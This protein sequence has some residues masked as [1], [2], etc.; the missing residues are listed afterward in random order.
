[1]KRVLTLIILLSVFAYLFSSPS[2]YQNPRR[3]YEPNQ[4]IV[5][6]GSGDSYE[7]AMSNAK[8]ELIQQITVNV[9]TDTDVTFLSSETESKAYYTEYLKQNI[10]TTSEQQIQG[11][12]IMQQE[13]VN[14][15]YFIMLALNKQRMLRNMQ[16]EI[17]ELW[18]AIQTNIVN[19]ENFK[20]MGQVVFALEAYSKIQDLLS[21][22]IA[23][24]MLYDNLDI[25]PYYIKDLI[26]TA[27]V[28]NSVKTLI[29][30]IRFEV[31]SGNQ[32]TTRRGT[33][34]PEAIVFSAATRTRDGKIVF[35]ENL[36]VKL[37]YGN[38]SLIETGFTNDNGE[39]TLYA[40]ALPEQSDR[41]KIVIQI[42]PFNF[43][44][45]YNKLLRNMS[46]EAYY[47]TIE[48]IPLQVQ[49]LITD[50]SGKELPSTQRQ[51]S[52]IL[53]NNNIFHMNEAPLFLNGVVSVNDVR[54]IE[55]MGAPKFLVDSVLDLEF[56][57]TGSK[58]IIGSVKGTGKG[59]SEKSEADAVDKAYNNVS[60]NIRELKILVA[61]A[62]SYLEEGILQASINNLSKGKRLYATG[63]YQNAIEALLMVNYGDEYISEA[64]S[65]MKE[66]RL[67]HLPNSKSSIRDNIPETSSH[68]LSK[69]SHGFSSL[70][71]IILPKRFNYQD[72]SIT[73]LVG[74]KVVQV[75]TDQAEFLH[76][77][78][79]IKNVTT[80]FY[81][82]E[83]ANFANIKNGD[84]VFVFSTY[85]K[86]VDFE[87]AL[88]E[89]WIACRVTDIKNIMN[90]TI[91]TS[92]RYHEV[93]IE[94][95]RVLRK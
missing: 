39:Y 1:M 4:F 62:E 43:P 74:K 18:I 76:Y 21:K 88:Y 79:D 38:D 85:S 10:R 56:G 7:S 82:T 80:N 77:K 45:Y 41:G 42:N 34:L 71:Y 22:L 92:A 58:E 30:S 2:W 94:A 72:D 16:S 48:S 9:K 52:R 17:D 11:M 50:D 66:I 90:G 13:Q 75:N 8:S 65:I 84:T 54:T 87:H 70:D 31:V 95:I 28:E 61:R 89:P 73:G 40:V 64:I 81:S 46:G 36:P 20:N 24:K 23:K 33:L 32:Q 27:D 47:R 69:D 5:G 19:A 60:I 35:L 15:K 93:S 25:K 57:I 37:S 55:G 86:P 26:S 51:I 6:V 12:E 91:K 68:D 83:P 59:L 53:S 44:G 14:N 29:A 78:S 49:L 63:D 67:N 3:F